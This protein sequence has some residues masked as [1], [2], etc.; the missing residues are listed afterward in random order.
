MSLYRWLHGRWYDRAKDRAM[1]DPRY[2][3]LDDAMSTG[4]G[5]KLWTGNEALWKE[6]DAIFDRINKRPLYLRVLRFLDHNDLTPRD[7]RRRA[8]FARQR[9][10]QGYSSGDVWSFDYYLNNVIIGGVT[11]LRK[12]LHGHPAG[13]LDGDPMSSGSDDLA[14]WAAILTTIIEGF[15]AAN[16]LL[17]FNLGPNEK[18]PDRV[19]ANAAFDLGFDLFHAYYFDLWD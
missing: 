18:D 6:Q 16:D 8:R 3:E 10:K 13:I 15:E 11:E 4:H 9:M 1:N 2:R 14:Y 7:L 17:G 5:T 12:N 19:A